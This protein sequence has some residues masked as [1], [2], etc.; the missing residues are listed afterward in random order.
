MSV[1]A[2]LERSGQAFVLVT[3]VDIAGSAP[4]HTGA[5]MVVTADSTY[6]T[7]GGGAVEKETI[8]AARGALASGEPRLM[9]FTL[10]PEATGMACGG[11]MKI[12]L[13]PVNVTPTLYIFGAGH[14]G[15]ALA[16]FAAKTSFRVVVVDSRSEWATAARFPGAAEILTGDCVE[17]AKNLQSSPGDYI[18]ILTHSHALDQVVLAA[19]LE[20][21]YRY[22]GLICSKKKKV[23]IFNNLEKAGK[24]RNLLEKVHAPIGLEINSETPEEI[25]V[26]ILAEL[27]LV[28]RGGKS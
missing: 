10:T 1:M 19:V 24:S 13:D 12:F 5:K 18:V 27:I 4:R 26:S 2:E 14:V 25:A 20:K 17:T 23:I 21:E 16:D 8:E 7:I 28:R 11:A 22:L 3:V 6:G 9:E 15:C